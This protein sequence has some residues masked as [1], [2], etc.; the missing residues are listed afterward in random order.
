MTYYFPVEDRELNNAFL[1]TNFGPDPDKRGLVA[2]CILKMQAGFSPGYTIQHIA[3]EL[4][5]LTDKGNVSV[6]G[7][8]F[9]FDTYKHYIPPAPVYTVGIL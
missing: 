6:R 3:G 9:L 7:R 1:G 5:L 4:G 8:L 2:E